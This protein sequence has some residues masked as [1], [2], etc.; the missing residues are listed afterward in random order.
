MLVSLACVAP[1]AASYLPPQLLTAPGKRGSMQLQLHVQLSI[2]SDCNFHVALGLLQCNP[3]GEAGGT[4]L[5]TSW[6]AGTT[7]SVQAT[8]YCSCR[9]RL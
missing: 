8:D 3:G 2:T 1:L 9:Q 7:A 6:I 4:T 5:I